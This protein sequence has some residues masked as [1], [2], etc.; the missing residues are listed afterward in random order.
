MINTI[1]EYK[2]E[3]GGVFLLVDVESA[4]GVTVKVWI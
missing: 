4:D 2:A 3:N 1:K